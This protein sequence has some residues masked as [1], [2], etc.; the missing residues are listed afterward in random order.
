MLFNNMCV[1]LCVEKYKIFFPI[2][3]MFEIKFRNV[4][5][6]HCIIKSRERIISTLIKREKN[7]ITV[8]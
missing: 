5:F 2:F 6:T 8:Y 3:I 1:D 7:L 4:S